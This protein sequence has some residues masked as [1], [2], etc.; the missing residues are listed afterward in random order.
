MS[1]DARLLIIGTGFL[2][3]VAYKTLKNLGIEIAVDVVGSSNKDMWAKEDVTLLEKP[4]EGYDV[5]INLKENHN[6]LENSNIVNNNA[7]LIEAVGRSV[8]KKENDNLLWKAVTTVRP[9][10]RKTI[11]IECMELAVNWI[12]NGQLDVD[13]FWTKA[14][15]RDTEWQSAFADGLDRPVGYSRGYIYWNNNGN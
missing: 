6:W 13:S 3:Y 4:N 14:Y 9:S 7:C 10:P 8:S 15:N 1:R 11:F 2:A 12:K 5:V